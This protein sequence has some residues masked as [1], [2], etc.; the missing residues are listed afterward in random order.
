MTA[1]RS[2]I[3]L[4]LLFL[5]GSCG[6]TQ[7]DGAP[8]TSGDG[9]QQAPSVP[10]S[11][12]GSFVVGALQEGLHFLGY[13]PGPI[14]GLY[15]EQTQ[16]AVLA[17]QEAAGLE[18]TG[19]LDEPT[20]LALAD[21]SPEVR[22]LAIEALQIE[23]TELGY[24]SGLIDGVFG[25]Q[26]GEALGAFQEAEGLEVTQSIDPETFDR[27][28][29]RYEAE[30][31]DAHIAAS[32]YEQ[33]P[34]ETVAPDAA[35]SADGATTVLRPGDR[36]PEVEALQRRLAELG[37][38]P[39]SVDGRF[40]G[41]TASAVLAFEKRE[42]LS[43]DGLAGP[44]VMARLA[45]PEGAGPRNTDGPRVEV[46]LDRQIIFVID[47]GGAVTTVNTSTGSGRTYQTPDGGEAVAYT[48]TGDFMVERRIDGIREA[49]LGSLYRPLYFTG[50]WA[51]HGSARVPA[52][53]ASHGCARTSNADQDFIFTVVP[54]GS[55]VDVYGTSLGEPG[56]GEPGF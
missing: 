15:G 5:L 34:P 56:A 21:S 37:Y 54:D 14:D 8:E 40:G 44:E 50:G 52:Y 32:G 26:T 17:F 55:P 28:N 1:G 9:A 16:E 27:L 38:R 10:A 42:G 18:T 24:Y 22:V 41:E 3:T 51:I 39:G 23:L 46:D 43:R 25:E 36:G 49:A 33:A 30:V 53:P 35:A 4:L 7:S 12:P 13:D 2:I 31:V 29:A 20:A 6:G 45:S 48:P 47:D 19:H 11:L